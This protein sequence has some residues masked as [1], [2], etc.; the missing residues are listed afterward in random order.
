MGEA[1]LLGYKQSMQCYYSVY[2]QVTPLSFQL[3][4]DTAVLVNAVV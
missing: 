3:I 2:I 4:V 1:H